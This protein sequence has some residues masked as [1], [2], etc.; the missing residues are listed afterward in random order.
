[1]LIKFCKEKSIKYCSAPFE[2]DWQLVS[3]QQQGIIKHIM[4]VDGDLFVL[5]GDS[6]YRGQFY[7]WRVLYL[8]KRYYYGSS[9]NGRGHV[10]QGAFAVA[11]VLV[12]K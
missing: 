12:W 7:V 8:H 1:M 10:S 3:L 4:T 5:G 11:I 6:I 2:A 9:V